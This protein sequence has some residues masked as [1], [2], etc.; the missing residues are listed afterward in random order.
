M[1][2]ALSDSVLYKIINTIIFEAAFL[3]L[4]VYF[5][6]ND[7]FFMLIILILLLIL[8]FFNGFIFEEHRFLSALVPV[9][10]LKGIYFKLRDIV[11]LLNIHLNFSCLKIKSAE[12][13]LLIF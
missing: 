9:N 10:A 4:K 2:V 5:L 13:D 12:H 7:F 11:C 6:K 1:F 8:V 3:V